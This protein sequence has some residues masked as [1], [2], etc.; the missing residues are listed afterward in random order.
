MANQQHR[1]R[2]FAVTDTGRVAAQPARSGLYRGLF[3]LTADSDAHEQEVIISAALG[4]LLSDLSTAGRVEVLRIMNGGVVEV[5]DTEPSGPSV[6]G[7]GHRPWRPES[8][9]PGTDRR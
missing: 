5:P 9:R 1:L 7:G 6:A 2:D 4:A 3:T 8:G